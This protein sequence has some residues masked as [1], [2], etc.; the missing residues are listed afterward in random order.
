[1]LLKATELN[2]GCFLLFSF[3]S[4]FSVNRVL[5]NLK[6]TGCPQIIKKTLATNTQNPSLLLLVAL[7]SVLSS[8]CFTLIAGAWYHTHFS[9][10]VHHNN[11]PEGQIEYL[12]KHHLLFRDI[13][14]NLHFHFVKCYYFGLT[15]YMYF[16]IIKCWDPWKLERENG[17]PGWPPAS[18]SGH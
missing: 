8:Q 17:C 11:F 12:R 15:T 1:M 16:T 18:I 4:D 6:C 7:L 9:Q 2:A 5:L 10:W 3:A 13:A 14:G